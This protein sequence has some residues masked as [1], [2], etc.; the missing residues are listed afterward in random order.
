M[1]SVTEEEWRTKFINYYQTN[2][3][4]K[5]K[6]VTDSF[7]AKWK[8]KYDK[9]WEGVTKKYGPPGQPIPQ[10]KAQPK[11]ARGPPS[12]TRGAPRGPKKTVGECYD[13]FVQLT[14]QQKPELKGARPT[15]NLVDA[16]VTNHANGLETATFT[17]CTRIR[18][19]LE[20]ERDLGGEH[21]PCVFPGE[22][23]G[24][25]TEKLHTEQSVLLTPKMSFRGSK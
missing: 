24:S 4:S 14:Q 15:T 1:A 12:R 9:L 13:A 25:T 20:K 7:M 8:G 2:A 22:R 18:P 21:F 23:G 16:K 5:V 19:V 17:V 3:P 10:P 6:V 11:R